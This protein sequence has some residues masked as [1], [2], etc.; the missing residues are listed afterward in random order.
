ML[1]MKIVP[2]S[3]TLGR[4]ERTRVLDLCELSSSVAHPAWLPPRIAALDR[5][6]LAIIRPWVFGA[7][8]PF[9][10]AADGREAYQCLIQLAWAL[11][12]AHRLGATHGGVHFGNLVVDHQSQACW[13]DVMASVGGWSR[14]L[15]DWDNRLAQTLPRRVED[16]ARGLAGM[17]AQTAVRRGDQG[18]LAL[19][20]DLERRLDY[21]DRQACVQIGEALQSF[22][23]RGGRGRRGWPWSSAP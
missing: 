17:I 12:A 23:D 20:A 5:G 8:G 6:H 4:K 16:D 22:L 7:V 19:L 1:A 15:S 10:P 13:I 9:V 18:L 21:R 3:A 11:G 14:Y 2:L